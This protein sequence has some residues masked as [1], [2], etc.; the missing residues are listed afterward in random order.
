MKKLFQ[1]LLFPLLLGCGWGRH[2]E[3]LSDLTLYLQSDIKID[4]ILVGNITQ[5]REN[6]W[7]RYSNIIHVDLNDSIND[8]YA[9]NFYVDNDHRMAQLWL[10]GEKVTIRAKISEGIKIEIDTVIGSDLYYKS[11]GFRKKYKTLLAEQPDSAVVNNFLITELKREIGS[12][13]SIEIASNFASRNFSR[14]NELREL[15]VILAG[16][17]EQL[18]N[19]LLNPYR[20]IEK[21]LSVSKIDFSEYRF[22][23]G[24]KKLTTIKLSNEKKYLVDFWFVGCAPCIQD[25][26]SITVKLNSLNNKLVEIIGISIDQ[27]QEQW[28]DFVKKKSYSWPNYRE[29]DEPENRMRTK[30]MINAFPTYLLLDG[31]GVILYRSNSFSEIEKY[32]GI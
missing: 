9:I 28:S 18:K 21:L 15:L 14:P 22:Y 13:F 30:M 24:D 4:S 5:D 26:K 17:N 19:H 31:E 10:D 1:I 27:S 29:V 8:M 12:P 16:Q 23:D 2:E 25:H 11:L 32:L 7:L 6:H 20:R 3:A